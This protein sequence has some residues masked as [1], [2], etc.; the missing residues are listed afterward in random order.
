MAR[1][2]RHPPALSSPQWGIFGLG[3]W[4][5]AQVLALSYSRSKFPLESRYVDYFCVGLLLSLYCLLALPGGSAPPR[6]WPALAWAALVD[7]GL[8]LQTAYH[9]LGLAAVQTPFVDASARQVRGYL[10]TGNSALLRLNPFPQMP[11]VISPEEMQALLDTPALRAIRPPELM[12]AHLMQQPAWVTTL[13]ARLP[14]LGLL[15]LTLGITLP[16]LLLPRS[17]SA[18]TRRQQPSC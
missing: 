1:L 8:A 13:L 16:L 12:R 6:S 15:L 7:A 14:T 18:D 10:E 5:L 17:P 3:L 2:L 11:R 9:L 4:F